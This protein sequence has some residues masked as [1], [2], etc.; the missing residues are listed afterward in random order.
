M[1]RRY[2]DNEEQEHE[3]DDVSFLDITDYDCPMV[4]STINQA[5]TQN[6]QQSR[7]KF[8]RLSKLRPKLVFFKKN[9]PSTAMDSNITLTTRFLPEAVEVKSFVERGVPIVWYIAQITTEYDAVS[10]PTGQKGACSDIMTMMS[11]AGETID[12]VSQF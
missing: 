10:L 1:L 7:P 11:I 5:A 8:G 9:K 4:E 2:Q 3:D 12:L 6:Q